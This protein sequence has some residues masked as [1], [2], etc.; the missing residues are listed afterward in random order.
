VRKPSDDAAY[1]ST[2]LTTAAGLN[3]AMAANT[4]YTFSY[5]VLYQ[6][7][8]TTNGI[9][10]AVSGPAGVAS[11]TYTVDIPLTTAD[12]AS[13]LFSGW[14]T[15]YDDFVLATSTPAIGTTYVAHIYGVVH[16]GA[17]AGN[18]VLRY[19]AEVSGTSVT[20]KADSWGALEVG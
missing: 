20:L 18:L 17:T 1:T 14:G 5:Y 19:R 15:A 12:G 16:N 10:L 6:S 11:V 2:T 9:G 3:L 7:A 4:A 13:A 8:A